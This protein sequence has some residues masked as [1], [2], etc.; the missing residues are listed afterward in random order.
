MVCAVFVSIRKFMG[1]VVLYV[2]EIYLFVCLINR[3]CVFS[4]L[5]NGLPAAVDFS[6]TIL[7]TISG[8]SCCPMF[9]VHCST[10]FVVRSFVLSFI[11]LVYVSRRFSLTLRASFLGAEL[12]MQFIQIALYQ[13]IDMIPFCFVSF[14]FVAI[15]RKK[16]N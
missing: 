6:Y 8:I 9:R 12:Q 13:T 4:V 5:L 16:V 11:T 14:R 15:E 1:F 7:C 3:F 2:N 10:L